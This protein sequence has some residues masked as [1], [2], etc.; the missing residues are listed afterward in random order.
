M[1]DRQSKPRSEP[2]DGAERSQPKPI[3]DRRRLVRPAE[4][5]EPPRPVF[6]DWASI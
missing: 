5:T 2:P 6:T 1:E 4:K 3:A